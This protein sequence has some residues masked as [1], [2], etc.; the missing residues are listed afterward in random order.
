MFIIPK[1]SCTILYYSDYKWNIMYDW[2]YKLIRCLK[3]RPL[4][5]KKMRKKTC[6]QQLKLGKLL[7]ANFFI[8][9]IGLF[10]ALS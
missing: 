5:L 8:N 9:M 4:C 2:S 6:P 1:E 7:I 10:H 3:I